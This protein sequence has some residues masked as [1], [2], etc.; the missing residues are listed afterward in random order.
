MSF[1]NGKCRGLVVD[2]VAWVQEVAGLLHC[3]LG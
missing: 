1:E 3:V 2:K